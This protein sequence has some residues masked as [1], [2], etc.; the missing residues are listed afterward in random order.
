MVNLTEI[1]TQLGSTAVIITVIGYFGQ[2]TIEAFLSSHLESY[3]Q[4]LEF[5]DN[6]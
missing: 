2:K 5:S 3:K 6:V 4:K 1:L